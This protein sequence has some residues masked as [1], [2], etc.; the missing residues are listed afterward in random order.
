MGQS[1][2]RQAKSKTAIT[3]S[4]PN[5]HSKRPVIDNTTKSNST[6]QLLTS[7]INKLLSNH[8]QLRKPVSRNV[9]DD[10]SR[11]I[12]PSTNINVNKD[13]N[14]SSYRIRGDKAKQKKS[15]AITLPCSTA[16]VRSIHVQPSKSNIQTTPADQPA[17]I[18]ITTTDTN[19]KNTSATA[20]KQSTIAAVTPTNSDSTPTTTANSNIN[21][22][23]ADIV[24]P[25]NKPPTLSTGS[26]HSRRF[27][28]MSG[29][30]TRA[31]MYQMLLAMHEKQEHMIQQMQLK[32]QQ[33]EQQL[34]S[35]KKKSIINNSNVNI[36]TVSVHSQHS[37]I[38]TDT[39]LQSQS[40]TTTHNQPVQRSDT[41]LSIYSGSS[42]RDT[43]LLS[44]RRRN[45]LQ[46][47]SDVSSSKA[48]TT[49]SITPTPIQSTNTIQD[50]KQS[51]LPVDSIGSVNE[52]QTSKHTS[53]ISTQ[54]NNKPIIVISP[55]SP[56][57]NHKQSIII[58]HNNIVPNN[59]NNNDNTVNENS[60]IQ[61]NI[62]PDTTAA[63]VLR[64]SRLIQQYQQQLL[65]ARAEYN[66]LLSTL[67]QHGITEQQLINMRNTNNNIVVIKTQRRVDRAVPDIS[68][69]DTKQVHHAMIKKRHEIEQ[70]ESQLLSAQQAQQYADQLQQSVQ[71]CKDPKQQMVMDKK[72]ELASM[73]AQLKQAEQRLSMRRSMQRS[74][75]E[76]LVQNMKKAAE[77]ISVNTQSTTA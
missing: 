50:G 63:P 18:T 66:T 32:E 33:F 7:S 59:T 71:Q 6:V 8:N 20:V 72:L 1:T 40:T 64:H 12:T 35:I 14:T 23:S 70:M 16:S 58:K 57:V 53:S 13:N 42:K 75:A 69:G 55:S 44:L 48:D 30:S 28:D 62:T 27:T 56:R 21:V 19:V 74:E 52:L 37:N 76:Q 68:S 24:S 45:A 73:I 67:Q 3:S 15:D 46:N 77:M 65:D 60:S 51:V 31:D 17:T 25:V 54:S 26:C 22:V 4:I 36:N 49:K 10:T 38:S 39:V 29:G 47:E 2:S 9:V 61:P 11:L 41:I 34:D 5:N 43:Q